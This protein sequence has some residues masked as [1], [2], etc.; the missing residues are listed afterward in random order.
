MELS[1]SVVMEGGIVVCAILALKHY[2]FLY[3][4]VPK[5]GL[6]KNMTWKV[7]S[8]YNK[9]TAKIKTSIIIVCANTQVQMIFW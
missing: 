2:V 3:L 9:Q 6:Q 4:S 8:L 1:S 5:L 7:G